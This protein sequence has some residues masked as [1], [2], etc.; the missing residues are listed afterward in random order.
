MAAHASGDAERRGRVDRLKQVLVRVA[1]EQGLTQ[2]Q[3]AA[4]LGIPPQYLSDLKHNRRAIAELLA[5]RFG[6]KFRVRHEW[7]LHGEGPA[8][9]P[10]G[11][12]DADPRATEDNVF[13][14]ILRRP[15]AGD[16][17]K[18]R[19]REPS[20]FE[21]TGPAAV[22]AKHCARPYVLRVEHNEK[23][24]RLRRGN[25]V[26]VSQMPDANSRYQLV[27]HRRQPRLARLGAD[28]RLRLLEGG[29][30]L[31]DSV[32]RAGHGRGLVWAVL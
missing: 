23:G 27:V 26:L 15:C 25:L 4:K 5:R 19:F 11:T 17:L 13:L 6:Q 24:G 18:S 7:L 16:P 21:L 32:R 3:I 28:H 30:P 9:L 1:Q 10:T 8:E 20:H 14:P 29:D 22:A 2:K 12:V 31:P